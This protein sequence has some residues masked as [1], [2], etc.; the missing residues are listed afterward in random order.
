MGAI[1]EIFFV[2]GWVMEK[3]KTTSFISSPLSAL[4]AITTDVRDDIK[5]ITY[6]YWVKK[7]EKVIKC[8]NYMRNKDEVQWHNHP[9]FSTWLAN[10]AHTLNLSIQFHVV[11]PLSV[12]T[13][14]C[15]ERVHAQPSNLPPVQTYWVSEAC[16]GQWHYTKKEPL[17]RLGDF[18]FKDLHD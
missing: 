4:F 1:T 10:P 8:N 12:F 18:F 11:G 9:L 5:V 6:S 14:Y 15:Q 7:C 13:C 3:D 2:V 17:M 16:S